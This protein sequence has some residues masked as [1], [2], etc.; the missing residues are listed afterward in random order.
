MAKIKERITF[1][2]SQKIVEQ[3]EKILKKENIKFG[4]YGSYIRK[5]NTIGDI[6]ILVNERDYE[7]TKNILK[8][9]PFYERLEI[10]YLPEEY[11]DSW[12][13]FALYLVGSGKFNVWLRGIAKR[14][15]FLLNQYGLFNRDTGELITTKEKEIFEILGVRFIP[16]E[17]RKEIYKKEWKNYLIK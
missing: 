3:I 5:E 8:N 4:I 10:Y 14:K 9:F 13:S 7:K 2:E 12:E 16:Y 15:N 1:S 11:K 17:K 6:D